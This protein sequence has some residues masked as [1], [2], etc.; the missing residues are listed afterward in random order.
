MGGAVLLTGA[1]VRPDQ[2]RLVEQRVALV[3]GVT[4]VA[5]RVL[6]ADDAALDSY[7]PDGAKERELAS[8]VAPNL[9]L[10]VVRGVVYAVGVA[11]SP[12]IDHLKEIVA[13]DAAL[14]WVDA[15]AVQYR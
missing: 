4:S 5:N 8:Q 15:S 9:A 6:I 3:P 7:R 1:V 12:D 14:Q 2:R 10:R 13:A 11:Q